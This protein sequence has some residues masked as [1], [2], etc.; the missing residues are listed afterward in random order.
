MEKVKTVV[1]IAGKEYRMAGYETPEYMHRV[2]L[3]VDRKIE[4][5][6]HSNWNLSSTMLAVLTAANI[7]DELLKLQDEIPALQERITQ[8]KDELRAVQKENMMLKDGKKTN[9]SS[10]SDVKKAMEGNT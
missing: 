3:Y 5:L 8:L 7:T 4:E 2:A 1:K 9:I 6:E 10:L